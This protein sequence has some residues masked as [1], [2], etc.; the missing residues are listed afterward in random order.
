MGSRIELMAQPPNTEW[1]AR[2]AGRPMDRSSPGLHA[3]VRQYAREGT[4]TS[5]TQAR[6]N[7]A[8]GS[9]RAEITARTGLK[10]D[11]PRKNRYRRAP[12]KGSNGRHF[13]QG[14]VPWEPDVDHAL[15]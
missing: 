12:S 14:E 15:T 7:D 6:H 10:R 2:Y 4:D 11:T 3:N 8:K 13:P 1:R 9:G 5:S